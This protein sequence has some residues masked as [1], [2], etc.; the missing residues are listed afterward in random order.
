MTTVRT[1]EELD[2]ALARGDERID[3]RSEAG[4]R[5]A[6]WAS[7]SS[8]VRAYGSSTVR[9]YGSSTVWAYGSSTVWASDSSTVRASDSSTVRAYGSSTVRAYGS[10][11][12]RAYGS[13]TVTARARV[14][15]H[16]HSGRA[17]VV[18]G[19]LIDHTR[20]PGDAAAW[21]E[22]HGV[23]TADGIATLFKAVDDKWTTPRGTSYAPGSMP[24][25]DDWR[26]DA[27][28]GWGLHFS[29]SPIE[30][31]AYHPEATR[32]LAVGVAIETLRPIPGDTPKAKAPRV[33]VAC[34]EVDID[35]CEVTA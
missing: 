26:D 18:G 1:Q 12:V 31:L 24:T 2:A 35:G 32:F 9:A 33:V 34:R 3:I 7:D 25:A 11:T 23:T 10:S 21:C 22:Y 17:K 5:L 20:E 6:V 28:C 4:V 8:T 16:L 27:E 29:P 19:V 30:A 13:S 14:A 15:V